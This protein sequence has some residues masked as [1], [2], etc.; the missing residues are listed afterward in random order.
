M[1]IFVGNLG[2][3]ATEPENEALFKPNGQ[4][5]SVELGR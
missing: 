3:D 1:N 5:V 4:V 2:P